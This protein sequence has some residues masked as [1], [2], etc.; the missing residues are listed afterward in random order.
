MEV[1]SKA[2]L[3]CDE[4][5]LV[6]PIHPLL[7]GQLATT[8]DG[9]SAK[10]AFRSVITVIF[11]ALAGRNDIPVET[12]RSEPTSVNAQLQAFPLNAE[13]LFSGRSIN[14]LPL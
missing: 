8:F 9:T 5:E 2:Y 4:L 11:A 1:T 14:F 7:N 3:S 10:L 6:V 12:F 13:R